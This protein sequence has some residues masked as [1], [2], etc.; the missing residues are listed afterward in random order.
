MVAAELGWALDPQL[1]TS[2]KLS[3]WP[4]PPTTRSSGRSNPVSSRCSQSFRWEGLVD[5]EM[6]ITAAVNRIMGVQHTRTAMALRARGRTLRGRSHW[7]PGRL[8]HVQGPPPIEHRSGA[9]PHTPASVVTDMHC[10]ECCALRAGHRRP[11]CSPTSRCRWS[12]G[13]R[14]LGLHRW[15]GDDILDRFR[16][17]D[18]VATSPGRGS[19][20]GG[21][22]RP[23]RSRAQVTR[24]AR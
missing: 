18:R 22:P 11:A 6:A 15:S 2:H 23:H 12:P 19:R 13:G 3:R 24:A 16:A 21:P 7:G 4:R 8:R 9:S 20:S 14:T 1:R 10:D 5:G 17:G